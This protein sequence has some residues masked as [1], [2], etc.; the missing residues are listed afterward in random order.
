M[1]W[2]EKKIGKEVYQKSLRPHPMLHNL[3]SVRK[4]PQNIGFHSEELFAVEKR[5]KNMI[6]ISHLILIEFKSFTLKNEYHCKKT[7]N[8]YKSPQVPP[9]TG[10]FTNATEYTGNHPEKHEITNFK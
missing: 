2:D 4:S 7:A 9:V 3:I 1:Y 5:R 6:S 8:Q 10:T